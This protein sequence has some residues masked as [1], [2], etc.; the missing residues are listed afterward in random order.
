MSKRNAWGVGNNGRIGGGRG[1][2]SCTQASTCQGS[3]KSAC[4][5]QGQAL[6]SRIRVL[7][8]LSNL[9]VGHLSPLCLPRAAPG[10]WKATEWLD[11]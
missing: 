10:T 11:F 3:L 9:C 4:A 2:K 8:L 5:G 7:T 1:E 6:L